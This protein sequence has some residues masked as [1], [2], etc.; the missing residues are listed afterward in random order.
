MALEEPQQD[1]Q[2]FEVDGV[3]FSVPPDVAHILRIYTGSMI[4]HDPGRR[5][6]GRFYVRLAGRRS[7]CS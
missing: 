2:R 4:D 3:S 5:G 7:W 1:D 6:L